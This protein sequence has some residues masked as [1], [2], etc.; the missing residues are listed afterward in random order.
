MGALKPWPQLAWTRPPSQAWT[1][2]A[3]RPVV[4]GAELRMVVAPRSEGEAG[5]LAQGD[6]VLQVDALDVDVGDEGAEAVPPRR[7]SRLAPTVSRWL[8]RCV[9]EPA[10]RA[11]GRGCSIR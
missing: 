8:P 4:F 11:R 2:S 5:P 10:R 9:A 7:S 1:A 6:L 3:A